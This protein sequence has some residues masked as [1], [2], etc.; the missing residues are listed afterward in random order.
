MA[1]IVFLPQHASLSGRT[2]LI[3]CIDKK[4]SKQVETTKRNKILLTL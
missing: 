3:V 2:A 4:V 1:V